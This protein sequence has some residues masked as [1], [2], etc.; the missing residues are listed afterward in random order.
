MQSAPMAPQAPAAAP[1]FFGGRLGGTLGTV[2]ATAAGVAGGAFLFQ[3]I[4]HQMHPGAGSGFMNQAGEAFTAPPVEN[5]TVNNYYGSDRPSDSDS[6]VDDF[7]DDTSW[8]D[9][10]TSV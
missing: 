4:E 9:G 7:A 5:T 3:G 2:A 6:S 10:S 1:G 8:D